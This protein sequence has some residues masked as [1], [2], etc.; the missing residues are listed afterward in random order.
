[1][2]D[3]VDRLRARY[4]DEFRKVGLHEPL[5]DE[6]ADEIDRLR[7]LLSDVERALESFTVESEP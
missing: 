2:T 5:L 1:M 6:A 3:L 4:T 7:A